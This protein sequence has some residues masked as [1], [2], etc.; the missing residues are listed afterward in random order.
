MNILVTGSSGYLGSSFIAELK[1]KYNFFS[2][3]LQ[4]NPISHLNL[5]NIDTILHCAAL[6]HKKTHFDD[7]QYYNINTKYPVELAKKAKKYGVK[8]FIFISTIA[9]YGDEEETVDEKSECKP[10]TSYGKSKLA[11]ERKLQELNDENF[12]VSIV[13]APMVYGEDSPGNILSLITLISNVSVLPLGKINNKR[14]FVYIENLLYLINEIIEQNQEGIFLASDDYAISTTNLIEL[15]AHELNKNITLLKIPFFET[16]LKIV[17]PSFHRRLYE[18]LEVD[19]S[20]TKKRLDFKNLF[21]I[22]EGVKLMING[23]NR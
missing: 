11:A 7:N 21:T 8:Q 16:C 5:E 17:K 22:E 1:D 9:V 4:Q 13:R 20:Q 23:E 2:F 18:N 12:I 15:I 3:S 19:N 6:V 10:V 14:S